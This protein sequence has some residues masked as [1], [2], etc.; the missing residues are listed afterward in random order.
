MKNIL[1]KGHSGIISQL[2]SIHVVETPFMHLYHQSILSYHQVVLT[3]HKEL[4]PSCGGHDHSIPFISRS[5][6]P[7]VCPYHHPFSQKNEIEKIVH[8][9]LEVGVICP[10]TSPYSSPVVMVLKKEGTWHMWPDLC[11]LKNSKSKTD[12]PFLS[13]MTSWMNWVVL[14]T[15]PIW[16]YVLA[17]TI[18]LMIATMWDILH[19]TNLWDVDHCNCVRLYPTYKPK[20]N[21]LVRVHSSYLIQRWN[22]DMTS[23]IHRVEKSSKWL[24][25]G[26]GDLLSWA[27]LWLSIRWMCGIQKCWVHL[28]ENRN[29][30]LM[31]NSRWLSC[32]MQWERRSVQWTCLWM[33][34]CEHMEKWFFS[35][36]KWARDMYMP[37]DV[38]LVDEHLW[39]YHIPWYIVQESEFHVT[40]IVM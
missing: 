9:L 28:H 39:V 40:L 6:C 20:R 19:L 24:S 16:I 17:T 33:R 35:V 26:K 14:S 10:S 37:M 32:V 27:C 15:S 5:I 34:T 1:K 3:T 25:C 21:P 8:E 29:E 38:P 31:R 22:V 18:L 23:S 4:P 2:H 12:S 7:N 36:M 13:L 30:Y 11:A